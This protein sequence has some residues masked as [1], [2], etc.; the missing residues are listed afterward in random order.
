[1]NGGVLN[2]LS[3]LFECHV[4]HEG[5]NLAKLLFSPIPRPINCF[6]VS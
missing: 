3:A 5:C 1:M 2:I 6:I 4:S